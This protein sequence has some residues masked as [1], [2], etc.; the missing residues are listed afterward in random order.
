MTGGGGLRAEK[1]S[2]LFLLG[3]GA[4]CRVIS[5]MSMVMTR[6]SWTAILQMESWSSATMSATYV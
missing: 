3:I 4:Y 1:Q 6:G 5:S 2:I